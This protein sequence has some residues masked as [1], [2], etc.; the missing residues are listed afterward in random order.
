MKLTL[1]LITLACTGCYTEPPNPNYSKMVT[2]DDDIKVWQVQTQDNPPV[3]W[4]IDMKSQRQYIGVK[5][6]GFVEVK[7]Q[8]AP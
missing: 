1:L 4:I 7:T 8:P 3:Y 2:G 6:V 5:H